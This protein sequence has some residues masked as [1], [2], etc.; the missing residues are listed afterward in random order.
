MAATKRNELEPLMTVEEVADW[1][2][3]TPGTIRQKV[4]FRAIPFVKVGTQ[5]RFRRSDLAA[6]INRS[7]P[8]A[9]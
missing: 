7:T 1:L 8:E 4:K 2:R 5:T 3:M 6:W 9:A